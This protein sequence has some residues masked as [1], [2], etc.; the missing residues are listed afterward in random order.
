MDPK[1]H[2]LESDEAMMLMQ[3]F[4]SE[5]I[6]EYRENEIRPVRL[7]DGREIIMVIRPNGSILTAISVSEIPATERGGRPRTVL[8]PVYMNQ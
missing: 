7:P 8:Q 4:L 6:F 1:L 5:V 2:P 3:C